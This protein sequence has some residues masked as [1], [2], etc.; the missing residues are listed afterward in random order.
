MLVLS[1]KPGEVIVVPQCALTVTVIA[2]EGNKVRLGFV[3]PDDIDVYREEI[4]Q[5]IC[6]QKDRLPATNKKPEG[7]DV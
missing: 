1:R 2:V 7:D 6:E 4:W 3:A 5:K